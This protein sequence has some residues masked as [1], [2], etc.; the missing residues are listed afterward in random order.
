MIKNRETA[1]EYVKKFQDLN[2]TRLPARQAT[3]WEEQIQ[4]HLK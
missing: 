1:M 2:L 4:C 3:A